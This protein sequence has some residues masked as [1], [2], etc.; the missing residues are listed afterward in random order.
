MI[1]VTGATGFIG[2]HLVDELFKRDYEIGILAN[3][4]TV[5][6]RWSN[7]RQITIFSADISNF[8][9]LLTIPENI[10]FDAA[11]HLAAHIPKS[12]D[13]HSLR[14]C[15]AVNCI[16]TNNILQFCHRREVKKVIYSSTVLVYRKDKSENCKVN[17]NSPIGPSTYYGISKLT[18]EFLCERFSKKSNLKTAILRYS[19]VYGLW[20]NPNTVLP[21]FI[22]RAIKSENLIV[23]G[24][25]ALFRDFVYVKDVILGSISALVSDVEGIF[26]IGSGR[27]T[28]MRTLAETVIRVTKSRS[29]IVFDNSKFEGESGVLL[30]ISRAK[31]ELGYRVAYDIESGLAD[32]YSQL[33]SK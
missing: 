23:Y 30:D 27:A 33:T 22:D 5:P 28:D 8:K 6:D 13:Y 29:K 32:Y 26:N 11:F 12:E 24:S 4:T 19:Y 1:L 10:K 9:D 25:G 17:E 21:I 15:L 20:Q 16:G 14:R 3:R 7:T 2:Q 18:G 31:R